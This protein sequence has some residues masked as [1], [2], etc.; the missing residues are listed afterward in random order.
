MDNKVLQKRTIT[1]IVITVLMM[2]AEIYYGFVTNSMSLMA[3]GFHMGTHVL[4]FAITLLVCFIATKFKDREIKLNAL[5]GYTS[6]IL[7]GLTAFGIIWESIE[8]FFNPLAISFGDAIF[9]AVLGLIIN[10][11]CLAIMGGKNPFHKHQ[12][13]S[14]SHHH[15]ENL[16]FKA[17]YLHIA[18]D[19]MTSVLAITALMLGKHFG[20]AF[21]DPI[22]GIFGGCVIAKWALDLLLKSS[23]IILDLTD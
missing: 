8:R 12:H 15:D 9:V 14:C 7:L 1:V 22:I 6:A 2:F 13:C 18:A 19:I 23:K 5:G 21:L 4:A 3:D 16:N 10:L 17:V 20:L 11:V